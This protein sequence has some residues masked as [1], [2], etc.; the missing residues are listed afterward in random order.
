MAPEE[1][2][3]RAIPTGKRTAAAIA[4]ACTFMLVAFVLVRLDPT[5]LGALPAL[6]LPLLLMLRRYPGERALIA[7][8]AA[9]RTRRWPALRRACVAP[10]AHID[11][12][13]GGLLL[14]RSLAVRPPPG[15]SLAA[16]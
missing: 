10:R 1:A 14:A 16:G 12:P 3:R 4:A 7:L 8:S 5:A 11:L 6:A 13:R 2:T 15:S 9:R